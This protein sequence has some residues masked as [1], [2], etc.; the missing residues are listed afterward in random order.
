MLKK[1]KKKKKELCFII[2]VIGDA[3][4]VYTTLG[5]FLLSFGL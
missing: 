4:Q 3:G 1:K 5:F 2:S